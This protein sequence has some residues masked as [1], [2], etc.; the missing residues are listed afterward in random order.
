MPTYLFKNN[1]TGEE[2]EEFMGI[3]ARDKYLADNPHLTQLVNGAPGL[4]YSMM[5][6]KP[7]DSFRDVLRSMKKSHRRSK[8]ETF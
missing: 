5:T 8:I 3:S 7:D 1:E 4:G 6:R 2:F